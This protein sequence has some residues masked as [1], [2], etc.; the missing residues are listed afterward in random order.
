MAT[1]RKPRFKRMPEAVPTGFRIT[2]RDLA[3]LRLVA[4]LRF[5][6]STHIVAAIQATQPE[7]SAQK[8]IRR[9][10]WLYHSGHLE[11]PPAQ[12]ESYR[13]GAGSSPMAY[14]LGAGGADLLSR[15][16]GFRRMDW[17][18]RSRTIS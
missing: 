6:R 11:R 13:A 7:A 5:A 9:L 16:F 10:E 8:L 2:E 1:A 3:I 4:R 14:M 15:E 18:F 12:Q 17:T